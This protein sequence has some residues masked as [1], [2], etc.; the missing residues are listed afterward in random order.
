VKHQARVIVLTINDDNFWMEVGNIIAITE[1]I[2]SVLR[3]S[4]GVGPKMGEI[5]ERMDCMVGEIKYIMTKDDNPHK[6]DFVEVESI[7]TRTKC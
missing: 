6:D 2:Y 5:Y 7:L 3:F 1:P 4:D